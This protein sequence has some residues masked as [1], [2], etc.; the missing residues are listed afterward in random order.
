MFEAFCTRGCVW[1]WVQTDGVHRAGNDACV[2]VMNLIP[3]RGFGAFC[4]QVRPSTEAPAGKLNIPLCWNI[5]R[6][7]RLFPS[8]RRGLLFDFLLTWCIFNPLSVTECVWHDSW[9][10]FVGFGTHQDRVPEGPRGKMTNFIVT[11]RTCAMNGFIRQSE[12]AL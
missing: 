8:S 3:S 11:L 7:R 9:S 5:R 12:S 10:Q 6:L 1:Y 2:C 4:L